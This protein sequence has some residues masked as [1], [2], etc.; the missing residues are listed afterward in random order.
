MLGLS[1]MLVRDSSFRDKNGS[2]GD[3]IYL[4]LH[5]VGLAE[6]ECRGFDNYEKR[7]GIIPVRN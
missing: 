4:E 5:P 1:A 3:V 6:T 2:L 7:R